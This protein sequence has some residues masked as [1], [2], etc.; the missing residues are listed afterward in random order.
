MRPTPTQSKGHRRLFNVGCYY[1]QQHYYYYYDFYG[2]D[3]DHDEGR[4]R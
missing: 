3:G 2:G 1:H 4:Q